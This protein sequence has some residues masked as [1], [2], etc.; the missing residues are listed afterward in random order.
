MPADN[1]D[2]TLDSLIAPARN[3]FPITP[4]NTADLPILPKAIYVGNGGRLVV[5]AVDS[6]EDVT[7]DNVASGTILD[8]RVI[9]VRQTGTTAS[10]LVGL[11]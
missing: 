9:A 7:F 8:L 11:S 3:C 10:N 5:R 4:N 6:P 2:A 1:F